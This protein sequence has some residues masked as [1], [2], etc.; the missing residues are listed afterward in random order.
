VFSKALGS[1]VLLESGALKNVVRS[2]SVGDYWARSTARV[3][4]PYDVA[5]TTATLIDI[6]ALAE[7]YPHVVE[8]LKLNRIALEGREHGAFKDK[9]WHRFGRS[10]N[11]GCWEQPKILVPYM[12]PRLCAYCDLDDSYY[13]INVTTGGYGLTVNSAQVPLEYVCALM[14]NP[15]LDFF[16]KRI[17]TTFRGGYY[18]AN[19]QY[20]ERLPISAA[21]TRSARHARQDIAEAVRELQRLKK[22]RLVNLLPDD[23]SNLEREAAVRQ[24][25]IDRLV[26]DLYDLTDDDIA[27]VE[28]SVPPA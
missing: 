21:D 23:R 3:L 12:V 16:L 24:H 11:L 8:Y 9:R 20:I 14:N 7:R 4:F 1:S 15:A 22:R 25:Q 13:F 27:L 10:Q 17:S 26:Y 5:G 19:K 18:A 2:G 6:D 28:D